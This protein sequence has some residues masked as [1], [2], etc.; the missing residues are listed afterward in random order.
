[1]TFGAKMMNA[2]LPRLIKG[3]LKQVGLGIRN[4][5]HSAPAL[6]ETS[7]TAFCKLLEAL[8]YYRSFFSLAEHGNNKR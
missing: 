8:V 7:N 6:C 5:V 2:D 3:K 4:P 1:M